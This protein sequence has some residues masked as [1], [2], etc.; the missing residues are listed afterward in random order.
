MAGILKVD[1]LGPPLLG[2]VTIFDHVGV[3]YVDRWADQ[4]GDDRPDPNGYM[5]RHIAAV[6]SRTTPVY[7]GT[8]VEFLNTVLQI[9]WVVS[10]PRAVTEWKAAY[11]LLQGPNV[12]A[13]E[14]LVQGSLTDGMG[15]GH[16]W[17]KMEAQ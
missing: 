1:P 6:P 3:W 2:F 7:I 9:A 13:Q 4:D 12:L 17:Y 8:A 14:D 10:A 16:A 11:T 15:I 5:K